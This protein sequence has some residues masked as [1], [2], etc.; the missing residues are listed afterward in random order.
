MGEIEPSIL[1]IDDEE[2]QI[3]F[4]IDVEFEVTGP[5]F[6]NGI[7]DREDGRMYTFDSTSRTSAISTTFTVEVILHYEFVNG[8]LVNVEDDGVYIADAAGGIE[9]SVEENEQDW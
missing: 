6:N 5:D 9:V 3:T 4:D 2:S 8:E 1:Y 7:Y